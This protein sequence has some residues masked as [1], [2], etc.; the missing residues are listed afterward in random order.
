MHAL[1]IK[2]VKMKYSW[3]SAALLT[4]LL[5]CAGAS[6][7]QYST[8]S[9]PVADAP[10]VVEFFSFYCGPCYAFNEQYRA[11]EA[12]NQALPT[13][14]AVTRY[15][16]SAMGKLGPE[17]SEA[18]AV[19]TIKGVT[20]HIGPLLF[21]A[22]QRDRTINSPD[23]IKAVFSKAGI[24]PGEYENTRHSVMVRALVD[25]QEAAVSTFGVSGTPSVYVKGRYLIDN[26]GVKATT[27]EGYAAAY[28]SLVSALVSK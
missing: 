11:V 17:L 28:A 4:S 8:L 9:Q 16:V 6:A 12:I 27:P 26:G 14:A 25:R 19:A 1:H 13:G 22:V 15:H 7:K 3:L 24:S 21:T 23:D 5:L 20:D 18:W 10:V 2:K